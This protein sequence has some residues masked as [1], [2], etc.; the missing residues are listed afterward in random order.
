M[1][2]SP[3]E[4]IEEML[5]TKGKV[6]IGRPTKNTRT[7]GRAEEVGVLTSW[8]FVHE[9]VSGVKIGTGIGT[10]PAWFLTDSIA[11]GCWPVRG[12][13]WADRKDTESWVIQ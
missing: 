4:H 7:D 10:I 1:V 9:D 5:V 6:Y 11:I 13:A 8:S 2:I 12:C 3:P